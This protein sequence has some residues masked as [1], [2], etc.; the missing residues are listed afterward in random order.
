MA[1]IKKKLVENVDGDLFV[2]SSCENFGI[3]RELAPSLFQRLESYHIVSKQAETEDEKREA[4][5][6]VVCCPK[7]AIGTNDR[8]GMKAIFDDF[9]LRVEDEV[10]YCGF[11][12]PKSAGANAYFIQRRDGNWLVSTPKYVPQIVSKFE[13]LGG[14]KYI[15][16]TH[17]DDVGESAKYRQKFGSEV[18]VH[19]YDLECFPNAEIVVQGSD[20]STMGSAFQII[21]TAGHTE[22][23]IMLLYRNHFL[24]SGDSLRH[25]LDTD[26]IE[27]WNPYWTWYSYLEQANSIAELT[28]F[29]FSWILTSHGGRVRREPPLLKEEIREAADEARR[30]NFDKLSK[31]QIIRN[32]IYYSGELRK[33]NQPLYAAKMEE[34]VESLKA[35]QNS[36]TKTS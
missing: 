2:D 24:F 29:N 15:F 28:K 5:R 14:V 11:N 21:P 25:D 31:E 18:I 1:D 20:V 8:A 34:K 35:I 33:L 3:C 10:F 13:Q 4:M 9:P 27:T 19:E 17:R 36:R 16:L 23:H 6:A 7:G 12:S 26:K 22:G 32:L 30:Y